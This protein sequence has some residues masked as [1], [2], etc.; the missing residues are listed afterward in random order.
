MSYY[1]RTPGY[2]MGPELVNSSGKVQS[3]G[4]VASNVMIRMK[5][6]LF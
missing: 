4:I 2:A 6:T 1:Q 5:P 3:M